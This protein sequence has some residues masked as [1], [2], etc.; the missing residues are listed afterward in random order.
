MGRG[1]HNPN[2]KYN[3]VTLL[4][5][6]VLVLAHG[7]YQEQGVS[8]EEDRVIQEIADN[9]HVLHAFTAA[10]S[11]EFP[12]HQTWEQLLAWV[13]SEKVEYRVQE[14]LGRKALSFNLALGGGCPLQLP[15]SREDSIAARNV[16]SAQKRLNDYVDADNSL[17]SSGSENAYPFV[18]F[19]Q[20]ILALIY[21]SGMIQQIA[22]QR[23]WGAKS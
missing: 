13:E 21:K 17:F 9:F 14:R 4:L 3:N 10:K 7:V 6:S 8:I 19:A 12:L 1:F 16:V 11:T 22:E 2:A 23:G 15:V 5:K 20:M 18:P